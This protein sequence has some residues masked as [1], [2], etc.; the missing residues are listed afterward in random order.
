[1]RNPIGRAVVIVSGHL[2][3]VVAG[4]GVGVARGKPRRVRLAIAPI[5]NEIRRGSSRRRRNNRAILIELQPVHTGGGQENGG[6]IEH[7]AHG[8]RCWLI[9][10]VE[11]LDGEIVEATPARRST[12]DDA[13][14]TQTQ[15]GRQA[16]GNN[17]PRERSGAAAGGQGQTVGGADRTGRHQ[18][19]CNDGNG[20]RWAEP[21]NRRG[22]GAAEGGSIAE[23][24]REIFTPSP[25]G[26]V[27]P[28]RQAVRV[29]GRDGN[30]VAPADHGRRQ[31]EGLTES[32]I[33]ELAKS[34]IAPRP[35]DTIAFQSQTVDTTTGNGDD[36]TQTG[37]GHRQCAAVGGAVAKLAK[38]VV[39]PR[40]DISAA[41]QCQAVVRPAGNGDDI[42]QTEHLDRHGAAVGGAVAELAKS[43]VAPGPEGSVGL[44][45]Q[46]VRIASRDGN[47]V[48]NTVG[49]KAHPRRHGGIAV[50]VTIPKLA[51]RVRAPRPNNPVAG[52]G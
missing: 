41:R 40:P 22:H 30:P 27:G 21:E 8:Q 45:R 26:S 39:A 38:S 6:R 18:A 7:H 33:P 47:P 32:S 36:I 51:R 28:L 5:P 17:H 31:G 43:V 46:A 9:I 48:G 50:D 3:G 25:E 42:T 24:A 44:L 15:T 23:L 16:T 12:G 13:I 10:G 37:H 52:Q 2:N 35:N 34:V 4:G 49:H 14:T 20:D 29:A 11:D 1:M 19:A